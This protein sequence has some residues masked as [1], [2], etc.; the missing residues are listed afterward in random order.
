MAVIELD[1]GALVSLAEAKEYLH[2]AAGNNDNDVLLASI[3]NY[4]SS[5]AAKFCNRT[6]RETTYSKD[7]HDGTGTT[8]LLLNNFPVTSLTRLSIGTVSGM[9]VTNSSSTAYRAYGNLTDTTLTLTIVG[10]SDAGKDVLT[11]S[12]YST[13]SD[14]VTAIDA[15]GKGWD[16][17][18]DSSNEDVPTSELIPR[19]AWEALDATV[20]LYLPDTP[21]SDFTVYEDRG[22]IY[23]GDGFPK[24]HE[25]IIVDYTAGYAD[26]EIPQGLRLAALRLIAYVYKNSTSDPSMMSERIGDYSY[27]K[28][29]TQSFWEI[30]PKLM[31]AAFYLYRRHC[32]EAVG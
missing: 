25:N 22:E 32:V 10:G 18:V 9:T 19:R 27:T 28:A 24:G 7:L 13:L 21:V 11:L 26:G 14:L 12:S 3:I 17:D 2:I 30:P 16:A 6:F 5:E 31:S 23:Y 20:T 8:S 1:D 4:V 29:N 15:L